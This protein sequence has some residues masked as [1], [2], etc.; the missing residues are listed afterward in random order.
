MHV[1]PTNVWTLSEKHI[2]DAIFN[3]TCAQKSGIMYIIVLRKHSKYGRD[4]SKK[5]ASV[6]L[7]QHIHVLK[8]NTKARGGG[9]ASL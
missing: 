4:P 5:K 9:K 1:L 7:C 2:N 8:I 6:L 3:L